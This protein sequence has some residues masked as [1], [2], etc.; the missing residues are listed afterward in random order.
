LRNC[1]IISDVLIST[2]KYIFPDSPLVQ[3]RLLTNQSQCAAILCE[4]QSRYF[5]VVDVYVTINYGIIEI[6]DQHIS[7]TDEQMCTAVSRTF[8]EG[9]IIK[10]L[11]WIVEPLDQCKY[12]TLSAAT[13]A[14]Q[15]YVLT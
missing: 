15:S 3:C 5:C 11:T 14:H 7:T 1:L 9:A 6:R 12:S 2:K 10:E 4:V 8:M 13:C